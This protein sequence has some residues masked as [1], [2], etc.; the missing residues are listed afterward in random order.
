M[1]PTQT[2]VFIGSQHKKKH[3]TKNTGLRRNKSLS[4]SGISMTILSIN[5][6]RYLEAT[7]FRYINVVKG[8]RMKNNREKDLEK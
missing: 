7:G 3:S 1:K 4:N 8:I 2:L 6:K 5:F